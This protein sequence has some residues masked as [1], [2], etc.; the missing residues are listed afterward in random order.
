[1]QRNRV[2]RCQCAVAFPARRYDPDGADACGGMTVRR[3]DLACERRHR[4]L[5]ARSSDGSDHTGLAQEKLGGDRSDG[6]PRIRDSNESNVG[7]QRFCR[8]AV[9]DD[10]GCAGADCRLNE[11]HAVI[12]AAGDRDEHIAALDGTAVGGHS[13][14][15]DLGMTRI[16][17]RVSGR[18]LAK[19][20]VKLQ[21][22]GGWF[23]M[24][25]YLLSFTEASSSWSAAGRPGRGSMPS[26][27]AIRATT[28]PPVGTAF[29]PDVVKPCV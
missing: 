20:H 5:A 16:E 19:L 9:T 11:A 1:M 25:P 2:G 6:A 8:R 15:F 10:R 3:P 17:F 28:A 24:L 13:A 4:S 14:H 12:L 21:L 26:S 29:Q 22:L 27:G 23:E 18:N 7:R